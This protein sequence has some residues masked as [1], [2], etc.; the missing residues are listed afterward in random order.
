MGQYSISTLVKLPFDWALRETRRALAEEEFAVITEIDL[1]VE[2]AA[3]AMRTN[4]TLF[5]LDS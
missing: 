2:L 4:R 5:D 3:L 1:Q